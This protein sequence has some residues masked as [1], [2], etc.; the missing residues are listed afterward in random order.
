MSKVSVLSFTRMCETAGQLYG[1]IAGFNIDDIP[2]DEDVC[3]ICGS[4]DLVKIRRMNGYINKKK[5]RSGKT[6]FHKMKE[7]EIRDRKNM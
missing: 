4:K 6:R 1:G 5:N 7:K 2:E 3:P